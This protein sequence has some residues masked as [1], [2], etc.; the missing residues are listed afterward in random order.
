MCISFTV[1]NVSPLTK[2]IED[3]LDEVIALSDSS[4]ALYFHLITLNSIF[5]E[6]ESNK[7]SKVN[8]KTLLLK[9]LA[10]VHN[11]IDLKNYYSDNK[12]YLD[13]YNLGLKNVHTKL[14]IIESFKEGLF[15]EKSKITE[16][17][18]SYV[19]NL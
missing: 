16:K 19:S 2:I 14:K 8:L 6:N 3:S 18:L 7:M 17:V 10:K 5:E 9:T 11:D 13:I 15:V 4:L 12:K 1:L